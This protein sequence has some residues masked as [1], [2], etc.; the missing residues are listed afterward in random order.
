VKK[1]VYSQ[2]DLAKYGTVKDFKELLNLFNQLLLRTHGDVDEAFEWM[3]NL[4]EREY[5]SKDIDLEKFKQQLEEAEYVQNQG[6]NFQLADK[7]VQSLRRSSLNSL[8]KD[9]Q[10][11]DGQGE[12]KTHK[13]VGNSSEELPEKRNYRFGDDLENLDMT[14][15]Y[16]NALKRSPIDNGHLEEEDLVIQEREN[17][18]SCSTV[19]LLDVSHSMILYG[20]DRFTPA[21]QVAL[22]L[23]ELITTRYKKD[24]LDIVLFGNEAIPVPIKELPYA[25]VGP[26]HTNTKA[27][28]N[29]ARKLLERRKA[30]IK[31]I[32]MVTDGKP[33]VIHLPSGEIYRN[34]FGMD[35]RIINRTL[36]EAVICRRRGIDI[37]TFMVTRDPYLEDFVNKLTELNQGKAYFSSP[38][39]LGGFVLKDFF[40]RR[41]RRA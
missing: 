11:G 38:D 39:K 9:F 12:H 15:S 3:E 22:A 24:S 21:K 36:D 27:G 7:G 10:N 30:K 2:L 35:P 4:Q 20:E 5:I 26:Y 18:T 25:S 34:T 29:Y 16:W 14:E 1:F 31:Q 8:F 23:T 19:L 33:T 32:I 13:G 40:R 6:G 28:I 41:Q 37:T 17:N